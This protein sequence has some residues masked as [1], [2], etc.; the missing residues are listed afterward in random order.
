V[1]PPSPFLAL[2]VR[3]CACLGVG[4]PE[5]THT[6]HPPTHTLTHTHQEPVGNPKEDVNE[7]LG[8]HLEML[9]S[10]RRELAGQDQLLLKGSAVEWRSGERGGGE[11]ESEREGER[12]KERARERERERESERE[13]ARAR[14][15][16]KARERVS[17]RESG[18]IRNDT[19]SQGS[20]LSS[21]IR[22]LRP[23]NMHALDQTTTAP[24]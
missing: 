12:E 24:F 23:S 7:A 3:A 15:R 1:N 16:E 14:E 19:N 5:A 2:Y 18:Y 13:R 21:K 17:E 10:I 22:L 11:R 8:A 6:T 20:W 4:V 9:A